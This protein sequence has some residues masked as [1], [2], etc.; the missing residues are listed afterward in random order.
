MSLSSSW[1]QRR[2]SRLCQG[3]LIRGTER[4]PT[5]PPKKEL[6]FR[7]PKCTGL[8]SWERLSSCALPKT[9][10]RKREEGQPIRS[11]RKGKDTPKRKNWDSYVGSFLLLLLSPP[12]KNTFLASIRRR[13]NGG[14]EAGEEIEGGLF[15]SSSFSSSI[16]ASEEKRGPSSRFRNPRLHCAEKNPSTQCN[17]GGL[18]SEGSPRK[19]SS[20]REKKK[21][22]ILHFQGPPFV[23]SSSCVCSPGREITFCLCLS[24]CPSPSSFL[25]LRRMPPPEKKGERGDEREGSIFTPV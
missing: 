18:G 4:T 25:F 14:K 16:F 15:V 2:I 1:R 5:F 6:N 19:M 24:L 9:S 11:E 20:K 3:L 7:P 8:W 23:L 17:S 13:T 21:K 10:K 12:P 22:F